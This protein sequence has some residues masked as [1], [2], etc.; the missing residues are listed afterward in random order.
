MQ[1]LWGTIQALFKQRK[2]RASFAVEFF[3]QRAYGIAK[4]LLEAGINVGATI[5]LQFQLAP[6]PQFPDNTSILDC[7]NELISLLGFARPWIESAPVDETNAWLIEAA[8]PAASRVLV[9]QDLLQDIDAQML[10]SSVMAQA[11][12]SNPSRRSATCFYFGPTPFLTLINLPPRTHS[13]GVEAQPFSAFNG[14]ESTGLHD[15][16]AVERGQFHGGGKALH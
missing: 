12:A 10:R 14:Y 1:H 11:E 4:L 2:C 8:A 7:L 3:L 13:N 5:S 6:G 15:W 16:Q 9:R